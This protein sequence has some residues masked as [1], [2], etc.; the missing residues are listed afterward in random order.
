MRDQIT[1]IKEYEGDKNG[2]EP[3]PSATCQI[4]NLT[5]DGH[6]RLWKHRRPVETADNV[7]LYNADDTLW[8]ATDPRNVTA[9]YSYNY[10]KLLTGVAYDLLP[11]A[12]LPSPL[13]SL[14]IPSASV[15]FG[16]DEMGNRTGWMMLR[17]E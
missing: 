7:Y 8:K 15:T 13:P 9:T 2:S 3:C 1:S 17:G 4:T 10:R 12:A 14:P 6:G 11:N 5:Y 16:Y